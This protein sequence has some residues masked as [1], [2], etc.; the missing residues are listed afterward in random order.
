MLLLLL[1]LLLLTVQQ[2]LL[3]LL[4]TLHQH[5]LLLTVHQHLLLLLVLLCLCLK[6]AMLLPAVVV[7]IHAVMAEAQT[8][9]LVPQPRRICTTWSILSEKMNYSNRCLVSTRTHE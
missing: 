9:T 4:L 5:L 6:H 3:L 8:Q 2:H 7:G 1:L